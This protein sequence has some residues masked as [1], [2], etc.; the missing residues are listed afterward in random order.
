MTIE[1]CELKDLLEKM[2]VRFEKAKIADSEYPGTYGWGQFLDVAKENDQ[3]GPYGTCG[4]VIV[5]SLASGKEN[6]KTLEKAKNLLIAFWEK[7]RSDKSYFK[8]FFQTLRVASLAYSLRVVPC[9]VNK[10]VTGEIQQ[11]FN[12]SVS[13]G[14]W[15][16]YWCSEELKDELPSI[17]CT[18]IVLLSYKLFSQDEE[19]N[20]NFDDTNKYLKSKLS[21]KNSL[22]SCEE[23]ASLAAY[24]SNNSKCKNKNIIKRAKKI[25]RKYDIDLTLR[26]P[27]FFDFEF[28]KK[29]GSKKHGRDYY[30][31][32]ISI[33][34]AIAGFQDSA[35]IELRIFAERILRRVVSNLCDNDGLFISSKSSAVRIDTF[36]QAWV[37]TLLKLAIRCKDKEHVKYNIKYSL[38][39]VRKDFWLPDTL[40]GFCFVFAIC[41]NAMNENDAVKWLAALCLVLATFIGE[42][43]I[44]K[45]TKAVQ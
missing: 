25:A 30:F 28:F 5:L 13:N 21:L 45:V 7:K 33:V 2:A 37:A 19:N 11:F 39:R 23:A 27:Y 43:I 10:M 40:K 14:S 4:G 17:F 3:I 36:E 31:L 8:R 41:V 16:N 38:F 20:I 35:P 22:N 9:S 26:A 29:D 1:T 24:F 18:S 42:S 32:P 15:G 12:Q 6:N 34:H 44:R